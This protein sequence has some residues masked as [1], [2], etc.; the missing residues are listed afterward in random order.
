MRA[1]VVAPV[2]TAGDDGPVNEVFKV[3]AGL[4]AQ[5]PGGRVEPENAEK[6]LA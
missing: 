6:K 5:P 1:L 3:S 2:G 4:G